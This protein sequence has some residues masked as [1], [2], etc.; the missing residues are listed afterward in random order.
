[1]TKRL[2]I[3][4]YLNLDDL[5]Y[6][7]R[8]S[9][10]PVERSQFH[11]I[12]LL[13]QGKL[14]EEVCVIT[15]YCRDWIRKIARRYNELGPEALRDRRHDNPGREPLLSESLQNQL[16][17]LLQGPAPD[18]KSWNSRKVAEWMAQKLDRPISLQRGWDY[19]HLLKVSKQISHY[20][21]YDSKST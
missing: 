7:Y 20:Q 15:G 10:D 4:P 1:M 13:A 12:W 5:E 9:K 17:E 19:M 2:T 6:H 18:G 3:K 11:I 14:T 8:K 16:Q 21:N